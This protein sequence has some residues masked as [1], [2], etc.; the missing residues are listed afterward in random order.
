MR[1]GKPTRG[2]TLHAAE[3]SIEHARVLLAHAVLDV[4]V[5]VHLRDETITLHAAQPIPAGEVVCEIAFSGRMNPHL[6]G[7]YGVRSNGHAYAFTQCEAADARRIFPCFD[8]PA[9]KARFR[10]SV[11]VRD[12][13]TALSNAPVTREERHGGGEHVVYFEETPPLSDQVRGVPSTLTRTI[14]SSSTTLIRSL[15]SGS[16]TR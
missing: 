13:D 12:G 14:A 5:E 11:T 4:D 16:S 2:I 1:V 3:L 8:E 6:R 15:S 7:L 9:M 10:L